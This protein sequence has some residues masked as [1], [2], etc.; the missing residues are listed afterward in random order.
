M[1]LII[2]VKNSHSY[3]VYKALH[4]AQATQHATLYTTWY[5]SVYNAVYKAVYM[6]VCRREAASM[7]VYNIAVDNAVCR[8]VRTAV[9]KAV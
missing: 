8:L 5:T 7:A 1:Y 2:A 6:A 9:Y 3:V 4:M